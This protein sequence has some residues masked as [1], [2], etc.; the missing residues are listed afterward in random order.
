LGSGCVLFFS[1]INPVI[2]FLYDDI[3]VL[4]VAKYS[5]IANI[6]VA[7]SFLLTRIAGIAGAVLC[8]FRRV[9]GA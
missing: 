6:K 7:F 3:V 9:C 2:D 8:V 1:N 4:E 5:I